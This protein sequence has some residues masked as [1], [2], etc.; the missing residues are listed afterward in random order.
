VAVRAYVV[1]TGLLF[2]SIVLLHTWRVIVEPHLATRAWYLLL[3][4]LA[5]ALAVW[6]WRLF[7]IQ[8]RS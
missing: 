6:A 7:P 4:L 2:G 8:A 1:T 3:T 5:A